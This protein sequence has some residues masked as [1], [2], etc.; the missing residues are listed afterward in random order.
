[1]TLHD[2]TIFTSGLLAALALQNASYGVKM[3][4]QNRPKNAAPRLEDDR[5]IRDL[6]SA[7]DVAKRAHKP[8]KHLYAAKEKRVSDLLRQATGRA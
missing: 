5:I 2:L 3:W 1:M 8:R 6:D 7:I 4:L